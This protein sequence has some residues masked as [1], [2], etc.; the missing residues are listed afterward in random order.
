MNLAR[1]KSATQISDVMGGANPAE[2]AVDD[3]PA[4][5]SCTDDKAAQPW[6][7]VEFTSLETIGS[8]VITF[9]DDSDKRN[10]RQSCFLT[11][12]LNG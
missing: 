8:V 10:C 4:T 1:D 6:W 12:S 3:D 9:P 2:D 7:S 11:S 5:F